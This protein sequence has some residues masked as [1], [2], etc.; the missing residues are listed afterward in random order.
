MRDFRY[1]SAQHSLVLN[2]HFWA[3]I[4]QQIVFFAIVLALLGNGLN[5]L[6]FIFT[7]AWLKVVHLVFC[8]QREQIFGSVV[9][10]LWLCT[11]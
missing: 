4:N 7:D 10:S 11:Y 3:E 5:R 9:H 8:H 6:V 1:Y 2:I